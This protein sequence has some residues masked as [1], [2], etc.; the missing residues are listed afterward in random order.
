MGTTLWLETFALP[1]DT[2]GRPDYSPRRLA[3]AYFEQPR[4]MATP[5]A[6]DEERSAR[7]DCNGTSS[8]S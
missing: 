3:C 4:S 2:A 1:L 5:R 7:M 6:A 8:W